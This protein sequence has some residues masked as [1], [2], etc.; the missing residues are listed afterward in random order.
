MIKRYV[1]SKL[2]QKFPTPTSWGNDIKND[3]VDVV[4]SPEL[5]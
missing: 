3:T 4:L 1:E 5:Y 2:K